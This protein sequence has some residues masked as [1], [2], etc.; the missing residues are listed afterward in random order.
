MANQQQKKIA[1]SGIQTQYL[2]VCLHLYLK[3]GKL[4]HSATMAGKIMYYDEIFSI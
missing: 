4:D 1:S 2:T 3:H